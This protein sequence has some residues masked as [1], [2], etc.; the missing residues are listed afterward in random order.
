[1]PNDHTYGTVKIREPK[2]G[3]DEILKFK[4]ATE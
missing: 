1:M 2:V 3:F 4:F